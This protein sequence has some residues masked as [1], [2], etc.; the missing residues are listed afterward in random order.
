VEARAEGLLRF[1]GITSHTLHAPVIHRRALEHFDFDS[2]LLPYNYMLMQNKTYA[3]D[4]ET[5]VKICREKN[6]AVKL[7]KTMQRRPYGD[8]PQTHA[9]WYQPF[10]TQ[11]EVDLALHWAYSR[12]GVFI[13]TAGDINVFPKVVSAAL[14]YRGKPSDALMEQMLREQA[15]EPLWA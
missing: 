7:I 9:T 2:V 8:G 15:A 6:V 14:R 11:P 13:N 3:A 1:I 4:F 10:D 5:L 12:P